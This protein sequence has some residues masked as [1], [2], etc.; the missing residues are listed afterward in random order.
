MV[1]YKRQLHGFTSK[2]MNMGRL[3]VTLCRRG[4]S[5]KS[6]VELVEKNVNRTSHSYLAES[7]ILA[8]TLQLLQMLNKTEPTGAVGVTDK[9]NLA[10]L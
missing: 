5:S 6:C 4:G 10:T 9:T 1:A 8:C 7:F 3:N 2:V